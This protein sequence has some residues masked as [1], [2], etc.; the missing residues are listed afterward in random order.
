MSVNKITCIFLYEKVKHKQCASKRLKVKWTILVLKLSFNHTGEWEKGG[1]G[2]YG[3]LWWLE[4]VASPPALCA[5]LQRAESL[6]TSNGSVLDV[7]P[8][9]S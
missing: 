3:R 7:Y 6:L 2:Y 4:P 1:G 8:Q 5:L 9:V